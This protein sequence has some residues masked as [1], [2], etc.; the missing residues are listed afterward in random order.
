MSETLDLLNKLTQE[1]EASMM[2]EDADLRL[3]L[4]EILWR[5]LHRKGWSQRRLAK[6]SGLADAVISNLVHG[7]RNWTC[8]MAVKA[9]RALGTK[10]RLRE[11]TPIKVADGTVS[12]ALH[13]T[14]G[15]RVAIK[16]EDY[17]SG[18]EITIHQAQTAS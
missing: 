12:W 5:G 3:D 2:G 14:S 15:E 7:N 11:A 16:L 8:R 18:Q 1:F 17:T 13:S 9:V 4:S 6:E 10:I